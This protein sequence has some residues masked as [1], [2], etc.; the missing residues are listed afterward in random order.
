MLQASR[1]N[2]MAE[3]NTVSLEAYAVFRNFLNDST[4]V[5]K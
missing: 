3:L 4:N 2:V 5:F 1:K